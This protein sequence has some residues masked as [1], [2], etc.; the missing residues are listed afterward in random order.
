M[1]DFHR[2]FMKPLRNW[3]GDILQEHMVTSRGL[4][5]YL[6]IHPG[7][8]KALRSFKDTD[9]W[10]DFGGGEANAQAQYLTAGGKGN[11]ITTSVHS[12]PSHLLSQKKFGSRFRVIG[13]RPT[14]DLPVDELP[15][16]NVGTDVV[17]KIAYDPLLDRGLMEDL[18]SIQPGGRL[19]FS[20][21]SPWHYVS[22]PKNPIET[23]ANHARQLANAVGEW[24]SL[25]KGIKV[26][27]PPKVVREEFSDGKKEQGWNL[28]AAE[29]EKL[30]EN[31]S[32]PMLRLKRFDAH[33]TDRNNPTEYIGNFIRTYEMDA[34]KHV[35]FDPHSEVP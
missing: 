29:I 27:S 2:S 4:G 26:V 7:L 13:G 22:T 8:A 15:L 14:E 5:E 23:R 10:I 28:V 30:T 25:A 12:F 33:P 9:T 6:H 19:F 1:R 16:A 24:L 18:F 20:L 35:G 34:K 31:Y 17:G 11:T 21:F 3:N 32:V